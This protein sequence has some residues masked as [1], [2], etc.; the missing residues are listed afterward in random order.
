MVWPTLRRQIQRLVNP[1]FAVATLVE[2][3]LKD[4][5]VAIGEVSVLPVEVDGL[6][7]AVPMP[8]AWHSVSRHRLLI[9]DIDRTIVSLGRVFVGIAYRCQVKTVS[10][11]I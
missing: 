9:K 3:R 11:P 5:A 6:S 2:N 4:V 7:A 1:G 8:E 10:I